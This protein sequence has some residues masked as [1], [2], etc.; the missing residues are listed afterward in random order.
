MAA[1]E[2]DVRV[3]RAAVATEEKEEEAMAAEKEAA[4]AEEEEV[5]ENKVIVD[6]ALDRPNRTWRTVPSR[7]RRRR[8]S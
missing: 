7:T 5:E 3:A 2:H 8:A 4:A 6:D 1:A